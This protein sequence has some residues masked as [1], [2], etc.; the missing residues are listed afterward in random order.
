MS[1]YVRRQLLNLV[2]EYGVWHVG[3]FLSSLDDPHTTVTKVRSSNI[4][5]WWKFSI[6]S[7][8]FLNSDHY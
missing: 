8:F 6:E 2:L 4:E 3:C 1:K 7:G 5:M